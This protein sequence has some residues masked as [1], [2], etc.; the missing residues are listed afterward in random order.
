MRN[1]IMILMAAELLYACTDASIAEVSPPL[2]LVQKAVLVDEAEG[3]TFP[4]QVKGQYESQLAFQT[5][6]RITA[7]HVK[8]GD[9]VQAGDTL[10]TIDPADMQEALN[11]SVAQFEE[12]RS[13]LRL[14]RTE[15]GRQTTLYKEGVVSQARYDQSLMT[16]EAAQAGYQQAEAAYQRQRNMLDYTQL[17]ATASGVVTDISAEAGQV[18]AGGQPVLSF[19]QSGGLEAEINVPENA[20]TSISEG[21]AATVSFWAAPD[22]A[23]QAVVREISPSADP[24]TRTFKVRVSLTNPPA[25]V[26]LGMTASVLL[27]TA[28]HQQAYAVPASAIYYSNDKAHV[29]VLRADNTVHMQEVQVA[30]FESTLV[31]LRSGLTV[32]DNIVTSG[33]HKLFENQTVRTAI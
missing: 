26:K 10:M 4:A 2:V 21:M 14:A 11:M 25:W 15:H 32:D 28:Q 31:R 18:V 30:K 20:S 29:W 22:E 13:R 8:R 7:R 9:Y 12:A 17:K 16:L 1:F 5:G 23:V 33:V 24:L 6:G 3:R 19:V 27:S